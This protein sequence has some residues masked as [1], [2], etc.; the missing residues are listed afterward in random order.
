M[1]MLNTY[2]ASA[3][4]LADDVHAVATAPSL[5]ERLKGLFAGRTLADHEGDEIADFI[6]AN[7]GVLTDQLEREISRRFGSMAGR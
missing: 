3:A 1:I 2:T 5:L 6:Q 7:G 4:A